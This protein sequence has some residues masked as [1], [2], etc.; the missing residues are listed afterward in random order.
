MLQKPCGFLPHMPQAPIPENLTNGF[1]VEPE[2]VC[3]FF[4]TPWVTDA[5]E[6]GEL[7]HCRKKKKDSNQQFLQAYHVPGAWLRDLHVSSHLISIITF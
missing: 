3:F 7:H 1:G 6:G 5:Q 2:H 4:L